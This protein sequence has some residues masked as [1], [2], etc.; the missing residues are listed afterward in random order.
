MK[1]KSPIHEK[2]KSLYQLLSRLGYLERAVETLPDILSS[3][4]KAL[5]EHN[6]SDLEQILTKKKD[7]ANTLVFHRDQAIDDVNKV[8]ESFNIR[9]SHP[10]Q[11]LNLRILIEILKEINRTTLP[12]TKDPE[13]PKILSDSL[14]RCHQI[15]VKF[16][17]Y[18]IQ[19]E[20]N[21]LLIATLLK[22][23]QD[24]YQFWS[25]LIRD[26]NSC[27]N[28]SGFISKPGKLSQILTEV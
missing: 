5:T 8:C 15:L 26:K 24:S 28:Q 20:K 22:N 10:V 9:P 25:S 3:E 18:K 19:T 4:E 14:T 1:Q 21:R 12:E 17:I 6:I 7:A 2:K 13:L 11:D 23:H 16:D 27:Y